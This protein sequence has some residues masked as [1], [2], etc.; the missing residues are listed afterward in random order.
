M[1]AKDGTAE[2]LGRARLD[3]ADDRIAVFDRKRK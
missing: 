3:P 1:Q 2:Q